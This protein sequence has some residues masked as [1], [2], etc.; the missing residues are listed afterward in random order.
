[1]ALFRC[2]NGYT[3]V[4]TAR[5]FKKRYRRESLYGAAL[6]W[7]DDLDAGKN[8]AT[9]ARLRNCVTKKPHQLSA[10]A[11]LLR[12]SVSRSSRLSLKFFTSKHAENTT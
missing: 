12:T 11:R 1:M 7:M 5:K 3:S 6:D 8:R 9:A 10:R 2:N 4:R